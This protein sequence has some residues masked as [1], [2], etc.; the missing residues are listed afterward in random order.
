MLRDD[1]GNAV[2]VI[3]VGGAV[4]LGL[5]I[6]TVSGATCE[7]PQPILCAADKD[8]SKIQVI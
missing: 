3:V 8:T 7:A 5:P 1:D 6:C 2:V 4:G